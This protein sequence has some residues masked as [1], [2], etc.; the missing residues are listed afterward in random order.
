[1]PIV[2]DYRSPLGT[3]RIVCGDQG[4]EQLSFVDSAPEVVSMRHPVLEMTLH[5]LDIYFSGREPDFTPPLCL[6]GSLFRISV[7]ELMLTIP[8]GRTATYGELAA[9]MSAQRGGAKVA[10]QAIGGAVGGNPIAIIVPCHRVIGAHGNLTG[11]GGGMAR[12]IALLSL[13]RVDLS[14]M[15]APALRALGN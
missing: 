15:F 8:Y 11:Y 6:S 4:V 2:S 1:M 3:V 12:K 7:G 14:G 10:A 13:E 5:W 9:R